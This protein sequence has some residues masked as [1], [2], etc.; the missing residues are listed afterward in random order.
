M[1]VKN[2]LTG[3][4]LSLAI[5]ASPHALSG[6]GD[7]FW[8]S[9]ALAAEPRIETTT[10]GDRTIERHYDAD[11]KLTKRVEKTTEG[12]TS[13]ERTYDSTNRLTEVKHKDAEGNVIQRTDVTYHHNRVVE[14]TYDGQDNL[15]Q[16]KTTTTT[17]DPN[18]ST[19]TTVKIVT[20]Q[21]V[22]GTRRV[23][24]KTVVEEVRGPVTGLGEARQQSVRSRSVDSMTYTQTEPRKRV[25]RVKEETR[26]LHIDRA[27]VPIYEGT[28]ET[29]TVE[30]GKTKKSVERMDSR[31]QQFVPEDEWV[32]YQPEPYRHDQI[33]PDGQVT[34]EGHSS[35]GGI[36][37]L[38]LVA[39][40]SYTSTDLPSDSGSLGVID[41]G[42]GE[43]PAIRLPVTITA[44]T[45]TAGVDGDFTNGNGGSYFPDGF[46]T[47]INFGHGSERIGRFFAA[48]P[49]MT[50]GFTYWEP[51]GGDG[52]SADNAEVDVTS[53]I[54]FTQIGFTISGRWD[55]V[56]WPNYSL[57]IGGGYNYTG[58]DFDQSG[59]LNDLD[60]GFAV[61]DVNVMN[62][63]DLSSSF[64]H[65][66]VGGEFRFDVAD[67]V[68]ADVG[69]NSNIGVQIN[70]LWGG[71]MTDCF[72]SFSGTPS[73][74]RCPS[75]QVT[76]EAEIDDTEVGVG[77]NLGL[78]AG[79]R[80][81]VTDELSTR[82]HAFFDYNANVPT[83][84]SP[85]NL[86]E[87]GPV[88]LGS[89]DGH[90]AGVGIQVLYAISDRRLKTDIA[91]V[92]T[93]VL[94]LPLYRFRYRGE[95]DVYLG[96][97]AQ[98][99]LEVMPDA[100]VVGPDGFYR[101]DYGRLGLAFKRLQ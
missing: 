70:S 66:N 9:T 46:R 95:S 33:G 96:V 7:T 57:F 68:V 4:G 99:V 24:Q 40:V 69:W 61:Y 59:S 51:S 39:N 41:V 10:E 42:N 62:R 18:D 15:T 58:Y 37:N 2:I 13:V 11:G 82:I 38:N 16:V 20:E 27:G 76:T 80:Y 17:P 36:G 8:I 86:Q 30:D 21:Y 32:P 49:S 100:V 6:N 77:F 5:A 26:L 50:N 1:S 98:D 44:P 84:G 48:D 73:I 88:E 71:Q 92:G 3:L 87:D 91:T 74:N 43:F 89:G 65:F 25:S 14:R 22:L 35:F 78:S 101:V 85:T 60:A 31:T 34:P 47:A 45:F 28:R 64:P 53:R 56:F 54:E 29:F 63:G 72:I 97:M 19:T 52:I 55:G 75:S 93:T 67:R 94:G 81:Q 79:L 90:S 23:W 12:D 83:L